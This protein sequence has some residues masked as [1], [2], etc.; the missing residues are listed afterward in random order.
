MRTI[1]LSIAIGAL[2]AGTSAF[3]QTAPP[4]ITSVNT[5]AGTSIT[6]PP[7]C[8]GGCFPVPVGYGAGA[9]SFPD[10]SIPTGATGKAIW[11]SFVDT[12]TDPGKITFESSNSNSGRPIGTASYS[13]VQ[14][15][16]ANGGSLDLHS[17]ITPA[18]MG[19]YVANVGDGSCILSGTCA[20]V[21]EGSAYDFAAFAAAPGSFG[22][23]AAFDF[24]VTTS[25]DGFADRLLYS[26]KGNLQLSKDG[27]LIVS[28]DT[29]DGFAKLRN[30]ALQT[31]PAG[32]D[33]P[34][35]SLGYNW[36]ATNFSVTG[37]LFETDFQTVSYRTSVYSYTNAA[38]LTGG[39]GVDLG[40]RACL[41]AYS[42]FGDPIGRGVFSAASEA[43]AAPMR[44]IGLFNHDDDEKK[45]PVHI[46]GLTFSSFTLN[47]PRIEGGALVLRAPVPEP[48]AWALMIMGFGVVG[49]TIR[50]RRVAGARA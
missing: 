7:P 21:R 24:S 40:V 42:G 26:V 16:I 4:S 5:S 23:F 12:T 11:N 31:P 10:P 17:T 29:A 25:A 38:C 8:E 37:S 48:A 13:L 49:A 14:I 30:F 27:G 50:R 2:L 18:G 32:G 46:D 28:E 47:A 3:A 1:G 22:A 20:Q 9:R 45:P 15:E 44:D 36:G 19:F 35:H 6:P 41:L 33:I 43:A 34:Y 39:T